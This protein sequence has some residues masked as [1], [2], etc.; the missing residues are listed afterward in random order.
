[1]IDPF[2]QFEYRVQ[3]L[4]ATT[5]NQVLR[6]LPYR[7]DW[8]GVDVLWLIHPESSLRH[9]PSGYYKHVLVLNGRAVTVPPLTLIVLGELAILPGTWCQLLEG[10]RQTGDVSVAVTN[11]ETHTQS[12]YTLGT[13]CLPT[14]LEV[15][16]SPSLTRSR[17][18]TPWPST[19]A[20]DPE[21]VTLWD[22]LGRKGCPVVGIGSIRQSGGMG[23]RWPIRSIGSH[24]YTDRPLSG[25]WMLDRDMLRQ[26]I[27]A[28]KVAIV[29]E[30]EGTEKGFRFWV[31]TPS[32]RWPM[33]SQVPWSPSHRLR[34]ICPVPAVWDVF[35]NG[36]LVDSLEG[37]LIDVP[38]Q[39]PG[40]WRVVLRRHLRS[41]HAWIYS[42]PIYL[43]A[44]S[45]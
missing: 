7:G 13:E 18:R 44:P 19:D 3:I 37:T 33:G 15:W 32:Q 2:H 40:V 8:D 4:L 17:R 23:L 43:M 28:G 34:G 30:R 11:R 12:Q 25:D 9:E 42:N 21:V 10:V 22:D 1:M 16:T 20:P 27:R 41:T 45:A 26:A 6:G 24:V 31:Q 35:C 38:V 14:G 5:G 39:H 36:Q 29:N